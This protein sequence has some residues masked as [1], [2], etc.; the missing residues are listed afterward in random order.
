MQFDNSKQERVNARLVSVGD[1]ISNLKTQLRKKG[2][3]SQSTIECRL[4]ELDYQIKRLKEEFP[5][6]NV[7]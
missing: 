2:R 1:A 4:T 5:P 7:G 3:R 6:F